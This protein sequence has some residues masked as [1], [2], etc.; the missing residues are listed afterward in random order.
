VN[1]LERVTAGL[2]RRS[3]ALLPAD[4]R[5]WA[6][7]AWAEAAEIPAGPQ[8]LTWLAGGLLV[9]VRQAMVSGEPWYPLAF[10]AAAGGVAWAAWPGSPSNPATVINRVD[11]TAMAV[12]LAGL[13]WAARRITGPVAGF[14]LAPLARAGGYAAILALVLAKSAVERVAD[15]PPNNLAG[16]TVA[17]TG[18]A[19]FLV[20]MG[21]YAAV[22]L[23]YTARRSPAGPGTV[24][25]GTAFGLTVGVL[26]Y[27]LGPLGFPLRFV[28]AW[29][30]GLYDAAMALGAA[31]AVCAPAAAGWA[32]A[33]RTTPGSPARQGAV[34]GL[35][36]GTAAALAVTVL[37]TATIAL[38]P[39]DA[40]LRGWAA[41]HIG[42]WA[43]VVGQVTPVEGPRVG[44]V[45]GNSA[46]AA[47][48][49]IVLMLSPLAGSALAAAGAWAAGRVLPRPHQPPA[50]PEEST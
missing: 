35:C 12:I 20:V 22:I 16:R 29:P 9:T 33:R 14:R 34:A 19:V 1:A 4:R 28:G 41:S 37:S 15:A 46:F 40:R 25:I 31:L 17:W 27:A 32:A 48:Y 23:A 8:R 39:Y 6:E 45:A 47:G 44:Y 38:L 13:S 42:H 49:L 50:A 30:A 7:A 26:A 36:A 18:E 3:M 5:P 2:L 10:A 43:P 11:V 21:G 24:A